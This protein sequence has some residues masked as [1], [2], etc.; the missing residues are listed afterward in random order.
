MLEWI[1]VD[2]YCNTCPLTDDNFIRKEYLCRGNFFN[3]L[4][5]LKKH[6]TAE[7]AGFYAFFQLRKAA[8]SLLKF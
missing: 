2:G 4:K 8:N 7:I 5:L 6:S 1:C 3:Y